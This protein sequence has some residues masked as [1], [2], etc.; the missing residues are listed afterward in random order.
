MGKKQSLPYPTH[1]IMPLLS[2]SLQRTQHS[3][4]ATSL[5]ILELHRTEYECCRWKG[6]AALDMT[7]YCDVHNTTKKKEENN[8]QNNVC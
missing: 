7:V 1:Q 5:P 8:S 3:C 2:I 6:A 4:S